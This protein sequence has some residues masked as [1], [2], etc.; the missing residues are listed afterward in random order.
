MDKELIVPLNLVEKVALL[1]TKEPQKSFR[2]IGLTNGD[3]MIT[4][5]GAKIVLQWLLTKH[6]DEIKKEIVDP[7]L[8]EAEKKK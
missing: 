5:E 4:P 8:K 3:D 6:A 1:F 2:K 7:L